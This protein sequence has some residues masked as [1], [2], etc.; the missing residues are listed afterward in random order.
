MAQEIIHTIIPGGG[1]DYTTLPAWEAA[2]QRDL[3]AADQIAVAECYAGASTAG[4]CVLTGWTTDATRYTIIRAATGQRHNGIPGAGYRHT[5]ADTVPALVFNTHTGRVEGIELAN[6]STGNCI[7]VVEP[8]TGHSVWI[9]GCLLIGGTQSVYSAAASAV[10]IYV[11]NCIIMDASFAG[12][13]ADSANVTMHV[14][15]NTVINCGLGIRNNT[16][17]VRPKNNIVQGG[18][19]CF[20]GTMTASA[21]NISSDA[22]SPQTGLR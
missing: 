9:D 18:T 14:Y 22:T 3:V 21:T 13:N 19:S 10:N 6:T 16:G 7:N 15:N 8:V 20:A 12:T 4:A 5:S 17:V 11:V 1:G 2:Q